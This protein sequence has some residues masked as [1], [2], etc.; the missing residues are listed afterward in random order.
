MGMTVAE[1]VRAWSEGE[2][3]DR[4]SPHWQ[5]TRR[6]LSKHLVA[7]VGDVD[8]ATVG[9][10][11]IWKIQAFA[12]T[13]GLSAETTNK[14]THHVLPAMLRDF[15]AAGL[16]PEGTRDRAMKG[17]RKLRAEGVAICTALTLEARDQLLRAFR[18][19]W[20][21]PLVHFLFYSGV[22]IGEACGLRQGDIDWSRRLCRI[23]RS[24]RCEEVS[25]TK[26]RRSQR[27]LVLPRAAI[28]AIARLRCDDD[29]YAYLFTGARGRPLNADSFRHRTWKP[30]LRR[31]GVRPIR[32]HDTRHTFATLAL[33]AG[34][35]VAKVAA[36]LGDRISTTEE[37]YAHVV[38]V[39][40]WDRA[41]S[42][43][44]LRAAK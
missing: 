38:A 40:D 17:A 24:R 14:I 26:S 37:R 16:L 39:D 13:R 23:S 32:I 41:I 15:E 8:A 5:R 10:R 44:G 27:V 19:H 43:P 31:A 18:G 36:Y 22:R 21:S 6:S 11:E 12:R 4:V 42:P 33:E 25:A 1:M 35:P 28:A 2:V 20:A 3:G 34:M 7:V 9:L 29:P 30:R